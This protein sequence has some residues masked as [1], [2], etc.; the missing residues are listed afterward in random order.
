MRL[1]RRIFGDQISSSPGNA[2]YESAMRRSDDLIKKME[3]AS[4]SKDVVPAMFADIW[5][6][7]HNVPFMT[8]VFE[9]VR[10]MKAA[11]TD[12][13]PERKRDGEAS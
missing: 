5:L 1:L 3:R 4:Q 8:T 7:R 10:E 11:T 13:M 6:Q 2:A 9:S 12:Q